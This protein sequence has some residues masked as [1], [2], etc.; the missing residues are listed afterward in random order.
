MGMVGFFQCHNNMDT[1]T[2]ITITITL[3]QQAGAR[4]YLH[5]P[6]WKGPPVVEQVSLTSVRVSWVG[7][8]VNARC[9][10][11]LRVKYWKSNGSPDSYEI[12]DKFLV[13]KNS[14]LV[15]KIDKYIEYDYQVI[16]VEKETLLRSTDYD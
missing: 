15:K 16:A 8:L 11:K 4:C 13:D 6:Y 14:Y 5:N 1:I 7:L 3:V 10:D 2:T 12:S 9:A